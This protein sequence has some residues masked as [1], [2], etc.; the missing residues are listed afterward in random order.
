MQ[1][2]NLLT[3]LPLLARLA[4]GQ[5]PSITQAPAGP[6]VTGKATI[7]STIDYTLQRS[8]VQHCIWY[9]GPL[10]RGAYYHDWDDVGGELGCGHAPINGCYCNTKYS[11]SA[12]SYFSSCI[13]YYC[14][15]TADPEN[16]VSAISLYDAY[17]ATANGNPS[18]PVPSPVPAQATAAA[19]VS[20]S[21]DAAATSN[22]PNAPNSPATPP[23]SSGTTRPASAA[24]ETAV[25]AS[26]TQSSA[27]PSDSGSSDS[28]GGGMSKGAK[29]GI[30][31]GASL[32]GVALI[33]IGVVSY[34]LHKRRVANSKEQPMGGIQEGVAVYYELKKMKS[35]S[36]LLF[37]A[38]SASLALCPSF[39]AAS[40]EPHGHGDN[41]F[42]SRCSQ[43]KRTFRPPGTTVLLAT[44]V[45]TGTNLTFPES[46]NNTCPKFIV[47]QAD[48]CRLRLRTTTGSDSSF[49][50][51]V[52]MPVGWER[53]PRRFLMA[54]NGGLNG[55]ISYLDLVFGNRLGFA[56]TSQD[57]GHAG[58]TALPFLNHPGVIE[59]Y[60]YRGLIN[61]G[62][63]G[64]SAVS[65]FYSKNIQ[66]SYYWGC[67]AGGRQGMRLA[68]DFPKEY[69]GILAAA[70]ALYSPA[71]NGLS[72]RIFKIT[73]P[74][75]A[76]TWL[77][78]DQWR[79]VHQMVIDQ[80]DWIDGVLDNVLEDPMKCEPRPEALLCAHGQTWKSHR[81]LT[82]PQV[83]TV[84]QFYSP[85]YGK[86]GEL[87]YPRWNPLTREFLGFR[88]LYG[89]VP[90]YFA[91][92][93]YQNALYSDRS[94]T[95]ANDWSL[96]TFY[97]DQ[98][99][100]L[101][102]IATN[103]T[104]LSGL[105]SSG[106][107]LIVYHGLT[108]G[109]IPSTASYRYYDDVVRDMGLRSEQLDDFF[110]FFPVSGLDHCYSGEGPWFVGGP[111]QTAIVGGSNIDPEDGALMK[112]VK[113][114]E[115]GPR[116]APETL[117][118]H[119]LVNGTVQG[120]REHCKY[121]SK[122]VYKG[123]GDPKLPSSWKCNNVVV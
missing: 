44:F 85:F 75:G 104:N 117:M 12:T 31:V 119:I 68:Q 80:C 22:A 36:Q 61:G 102:G 60:V 113:W 67:S 76:P 17:C 114:V 78:L 7:W 47:T 15:S 90:S 120:K 43:L 79:R 73:G 41:D 9:N 14:G 81:C 74:P 19:K 26:G 88:V 57:N 99:A 2:H 77:S 18:K 98:R 42:K 29:I 110:R 8:C 13:P 33:A 59:D 100:N 111:A 115:G 103:K 21:A 82:S 123:T 20:S 32:G 6:E 94:W 65:H 16:L 10:P 1:R 118:G 92:E 25:G 71:G 66:K 91:Q 51:E 84:R 5:D 27:S 58:D 112:L 11:S 52:F 50:S 64:K 122:T 4:A 108:D 55:C 54:G 49:I 45:A 69:D 62:R 48:I 95:I 39:G 97:D 30:A 86:N 53:G 83:N 105:K 38:L 70:P 109:L 89:G 28:N 93:W 35:A 121:P 106:A 34:M 101:Y 107:K 87:I 37:L 116:H 3:V 40:P 23:A 46:A 96:D 24:A 63:L 56:T 72:A